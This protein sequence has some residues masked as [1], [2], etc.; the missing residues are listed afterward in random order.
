MKNA[1]RMRLGAWV[2]DFH[3]SLGKSLRKVDWKNGRN[4]ASSVWSYPRAFL[5]LFEM[6]AVWIH[7]AK[8]RWEYWGNWWSLSWLPLSL[9]VSTDE[10]N[11]WGNFVDFQR[12]SFIDLHFFNHHPFGWQHKS[13]SSIR[14][15]LRSSALITSSSL[16]GHFKRGSHPENRFQ[17]AIQRFTNLNCK[18][19][20]DLRRRR[21]VFVHFL[22]NDQWGLYS[23]GTFG[24]WDSYCEDGMAAVCCYFG[25]VA[26]WIED[27]R[28]SYVN[29]LCATMMSENSGDLDHAN[30]YAV[31]DAKPV[32]KPD[33]FQEFELKEKTVISHNVAM[34]EIPLTLQEYGIFSTDTSIATDSPFLNLHRFLVSLSVNTSP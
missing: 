28:F 1:T 31:A 3:S 24:R 26:W 30:W 18:G 11:E 33:A 16:F 21:D 7:E 2:K 25:F 15:I 8:V 12:S 6:L 20:Q 13:D 9:A 34:Y 4:T 19:A 27:L 32:L 17:K 14:F 29:Y 10:K 23:L 5:R 22:G